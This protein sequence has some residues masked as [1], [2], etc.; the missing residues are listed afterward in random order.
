MTRPEHKK[1]HDSTTFLDLPQRV[2][3]GLL[4][5]LSASSAG[6]GLALSLPEP[7]RYAALAGTS[8]PIALGGYMAFKD[9]GYFKLMESIRRFPWAWALV[10]LQFLAAM[11]F[12]LGTL[13]VLG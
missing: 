11:M 10:A 1:S 7:A 13:R 9:R 12:A 6:L 4:M 8:L 5:A 3:V 2:V